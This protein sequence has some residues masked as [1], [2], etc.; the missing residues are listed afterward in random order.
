MKPLET[1]NDF[2]TQAA[3]FYLA[4][5]DGDRPKCR[6]VAFHLLREGKL[7]FGIGDF[8]AVYRQM[9]A[10]PQVEFCA[11]L[12]KRFLWYFGRAA[13]EPDDTL[14]QEVLAAG[15]AVELAAAFVAV[16][17]SAVTVVGLAAALV[18]GPVGAS[19]TLSAALPVA[20]GRCS[21]A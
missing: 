6:P 18:A 5:V 15:F 8:K 10:N 1:I 11:V 12:G 7:Y 21:F 17:P 4:T 16:V 19:D 2:L 9:Q 14:A 20:A 3:P 13:F